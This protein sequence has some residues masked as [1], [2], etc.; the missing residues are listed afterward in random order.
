MRKL[1]LSLCIIG[2]SQFLFGQ[3]TPPDAPAPPPP[4]KNKHGEEIVICNKGDKQMN[5]TVQ[6]NGDSITVNG[7]PLSDFKDADVTINKRKMMV[8][9]GNMTLDFNNMNGGDWGLKNMYDQLGK[10]S[11]YPFLGVTTDKVKD[12][13]KIDEL[14]PSGAA[15]KA[16]LKEGDI[17]TKVDDDYISNPETLSSV[18][19]SKKPQQEIKVYYKRGGKENSMKIKLG[20]HKEKITRTITFDAPMMRSFSIPSPD[21]MDENDIPYMPDMPDMADMGMPQRKKIGIKIQDTEDGKVKVINVEDS[22]AAANAGIKKDDIITEIDGEKIDNTDE[23]REQLHPEEGK[24][25]YNI[26][27]NR[28]GKEI[29]FD[30]KIPRKL[31]T[32]NL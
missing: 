21:E 31:K 24:M 32:A 16:G 4:A 30:V 22:S 15:E 11:S 8:R 9:D 25:S 28:S 5:I 27:I 2:F 7:K 17:I 18:I 3:D 14:V 20:E 1:L 26:K 12:G 29:S 10:A 6:I 13:V 23:A 19:R